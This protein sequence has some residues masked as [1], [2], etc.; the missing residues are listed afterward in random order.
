VSQIG[1]MPT[2]TALPPDVLEELTRLRLLNRGLE[3]RVRQLQE[4]LD[5]RIVIEQ[6]KG[7]LA[8]R[9]GIGMEKAFE[10]MRRAARRHR[11]KLRALATWIVVSAETPTVIVAE[12]GRA[13]R[14]DD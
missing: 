13:A 5:S 8:E 3:D 11:L 7:M 6:A 12:L 10:L 1:R 2:L 14:R 9:L 4:A